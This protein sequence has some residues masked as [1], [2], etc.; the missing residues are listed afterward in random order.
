MRRYQLINHL[1]ERNDYRRYLEIGVAQGIAFRAVRCPLKHGVDPVSPHATFQVTSDEFF[2]TLSRETSYDLIFVD[3]LHLE[4]QVRRDI[5][6]SLAHL[7]DQ[8]TIVVHDCNPPSRWYQRP[9]EDALQCGG[10]HWQWR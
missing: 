2:R 6:N 4:E 10:S 9:W 3:G 1:I 7:S 5:E 8:G